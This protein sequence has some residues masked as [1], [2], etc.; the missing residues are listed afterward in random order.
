M[1]G[2]LALH[3]VDL[4]GLKPGF[5]CGVAP[6]FEAEFLGES[7]GGGA[8]PAPRRER[9][10]G[11]RAAPARLGSLHLT[12]AA[13][14]AIARA[15]DRERYQTCTPGGRGDRGADGGTALTRASVFALARGIETGLTLHVGP[16]TFQPV[17]RRT[18]RST[19]W[20]PK[21]FRL[22]P[23]GGAIARAEDRADARRGRH[24]SVRPGGE[25]ARGR[26]GRAG[27]VVQ[28]LHQPATASAPSTRCSPT[29]PAAHLTP[30]PGRSL[31]GTGAIL[32]YQ[33]AI[34][35]VSASTRTATPC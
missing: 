35:R 13:T 15:I 17:V 12:F 21:A 30:R 23:D 18:S 34:A 32:A 24:D 11:R 28:H 22:P 19:G 20:S 14:R 2:D 3:G 4:R 25:R 1:E 31:C 9:R 7:E 6:G 27:E 5:V 8:R 29:S 10:S 33:Q 16:G 26:R